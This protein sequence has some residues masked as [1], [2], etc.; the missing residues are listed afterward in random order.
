[1]A[2]IF[3]EGDHVFVK[4]MQDINRVH[5]KDIIVFDTDGC[6]SYTLK[7]WDKAGV[8]VPL[9]TKHDVITLAQCPG[10][11]LYGRAIGLERTF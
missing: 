6:G 7:M 5:H 4:K 3:Q 9:N 2:P 1:M 10:S 8:L 11:R